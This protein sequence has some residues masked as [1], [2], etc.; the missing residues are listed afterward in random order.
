VLQTTTAIA[1]DSVEDGWAATNGSAG[2]SLAACS[3]WTATANRTWD[4]MR[5]R[6][7]ERERE[8]RWR[9]G[10]GGKWRVEPSQLFP[11]WLACR[12]PWLDPYWSR[13]A[14]GCWTDFQARPNTGADLG[15][16]IRAHLSLPIQK[17]I[18]GNRWRYSHHHIVDSGSSLFV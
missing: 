3:W 16:P 14:H 15:H 1:D 6:E 11:T 8:R 7:R 2:D 4:C 10:E 9:Y 17:T 18:R 12:R 13:P 5:E